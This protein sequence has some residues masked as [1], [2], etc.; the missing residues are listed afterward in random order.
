[1]NLILKDISKGDDI[2]TNLYIQLSINLRN[3]RSQTSE[4]TQNHIYIFLLFLSI[5][6]TQLSFS[7]TVLP[8]ILNNLF[9]CMCRIIV[10]YYFV[11]ATYI[12][13]FQHFLLYIHNIQ[14]LSHKTYSLSSSSS[15]SSS[16]SYF[17]FHRYLVLRYFFSFL[18]FSSCAL[19]QSC[20]P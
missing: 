10:Y 16:S 6:N 20:L 18:C 1:M 13:K 3:V 5:L 7:R 12:L 8:K 4:P 17:S 15:S 11:P 9:M 2:Q 19:S 14:P